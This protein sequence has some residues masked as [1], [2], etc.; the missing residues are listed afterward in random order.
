MAVV[1]VPEALDAGEVARRVRLKTG[2]RLSLAAR[3]GDAT[4]VLGCNDEK[5]YINVAGLVE[6]LASRH[7]WMHSTPGG[8]RVG[9]LRV[10]GMGEHPE[11]ME[12]LIGDIVRQKSIL[13]G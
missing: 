2:A 12:T 13:Y 4:V 7:A 5:R 8:D 3:S 1:E 11:R 6:A 9:R 10:E